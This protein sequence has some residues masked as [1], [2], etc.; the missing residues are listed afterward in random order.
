[1][2]FAPL[3]I[4]GA[5]SEKLRRLASGVGSGANARNAMLTGGRRCYLDVAVQIETPVQTS[6]QHL[7]DIMMILNLTFFDGRFQ[8]SLDQFD[9]F[10]R[11]CFIE[12]IFAKDLVADGIQNQ[13]LDVSISIILHVLFS[14]RL[15]LH[16]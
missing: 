12:Y 5:P 2:R 10:S 4:N 9:I 13:F 11:E 3:D 6:F 14:S 15:Q 7:H 16:R 1:M 8:Q